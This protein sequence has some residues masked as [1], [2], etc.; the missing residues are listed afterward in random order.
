MSQE[1]IDKTQD[2]EGLAA[3]PTPF[4]EPAKAAGV[5][6]G[7][8]IRSTGLGG[9]TPLAPLTVTPPRT[10]RPN[11]DVLAELPSLSDS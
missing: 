5:I 2:S 1:R 10:D 8:L 11:P 3:S 4:F 7:W 9:L 6:R